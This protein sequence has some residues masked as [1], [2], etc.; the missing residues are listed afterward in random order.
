[1]YIA[2][3]QK[4]GIGNFIKEEDSGSLFAPQQGAAR[5]NHFQKAPHP[6]LFLSQFHSYLTS[7]IAPTIYSNIVSCDS[8]FIHFVGNTCRFI[9]LGASSA[10]FQQIL[11]I[12]EEKR[13]F[14]FWEYLFRIFGIVSLQRMV[15]TKS[16]KSRTQSQ[17]ESHG[18]YLL[19][20]C[21]GRATVARLLK[22]INTQNRSLPPS[23]PFAALLL[24]SL[25]IYR[26]VKRKNQQ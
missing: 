1:M 10:L 8:P 2:N 12:P 13:Q 21:F 11:K 14:L 20:V 23:P 24:L 22:P 7:A 4:R 17:I 18:Q 26:E 16:L 19:L 15:L 5:Q 9:F 6:L 3:L 25:M